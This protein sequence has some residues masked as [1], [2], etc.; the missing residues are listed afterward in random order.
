MMEAYAVLDDVSEMTIL[1]HEAAQ[2]SKVSPV[3]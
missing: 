3:I 2:H 1:I